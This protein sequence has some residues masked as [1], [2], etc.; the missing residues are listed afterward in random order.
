M[1]RPRVQNP[2]RMIG[3]ASPADYPPTEKQPRGRPRTRW[4]DYI[5]DLAWS[6]IHVE[7]AEL[8]EI[9]ENREVFRYL[10]LPPAIL[11]GKTDVKS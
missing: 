11:R 2:K 3:G 1:V 8:S 4:C 9:A 7:P 5:S 10:L 6:Q